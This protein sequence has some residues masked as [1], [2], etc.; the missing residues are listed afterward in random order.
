MTYI[1]QKN[2]FYLIP[3]FLLLASCSSLGISSPWGNGGRYS[4]SGASLWGSGLNDNGLHNGRERGIASWYGPTFYGKRTASGAIFRKYALTAAHR[5]L[6][7]G[8]KV[9]VHNL[10][11]NES[12][13][14]IINDRGPF[15]SGRIIDLS[16]RAAKAIGMLARG[17]APVEITVLNG[18]E[19][20]LNQEETGL[21]EVQVGSFATYEEARSYLRRLS[22]YAGAHIVKSQYSGGTLYRVR[23]G[24]FDS[25]QKAQQYS[26]KVKPILGEAFV[27][28]Q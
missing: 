10:A 3:F 2:S 7:L 26:R 5:T 22:Q 17:T 18:T 19:S 4:G 8:T 24:K 1:F 14:V 13:D 16:W 9:R 15:V 20:P 21:F 27:V 12:V 28:R 6:P 23:V 11:N 25:L